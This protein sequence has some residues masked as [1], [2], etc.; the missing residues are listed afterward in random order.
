MPSP[1]HDAI[2]QLIEHDPQ[3]AVTIARDYLGDA[4]PAEEPVWL[5]PS[6]FND[7][8]SADFDCDAVVV[9]GPQHDPVRAIIV[10]AQR[11]KIDDKRRMFAKYAAELWVLLNCPIDVIVICPDEATCD[12]YAEPFRTSLPGYI[13]TARPLNPADVPV[14]T[15]AEQMAKDPGFADLTLAFHGDVPGVVEAFARGMTLLGEAGKDY[16][17]YGL[18][19]VAAPLRRRLE[20]LMAGKIYFSDWGKKAYA[21]GEADGL[22]RGEVEGLIKGRVEGRAEGRAEA[23]REGILRVLKLRRLELTD[24]DRDRILSCQDLVLLRAWLDRAITAD[25]ATEIF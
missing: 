2:T 14:I 5:G 20:E 4:I 23:E 7:R 16:Y 24:E 6:K 9:V 11:A 8:P 21:D 18:G 19:L 10:E 3:L 13:H 25:T 1:W 22:A 17:N 15:E 12:F